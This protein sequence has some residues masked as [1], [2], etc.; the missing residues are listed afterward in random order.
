MAVDHIQS[1]RELIAELRKEMIGPDPSGNYLDCTQHLKF[2]NYGE[3]LGPWRQAGNGEEILTHDNPTI[4]YGMGVLY[5]RRS[6]IQE[7][8]EDSDGDEAVPD[9][10]AVNV[11]DRL[12][13]EELEALE[14]A[15][16]SLGRA[17][18]SEGGDEFHLSLA[19]EYQPSCLGISFLADVTDDAALVVD[20]TG[21]RY[22]SIDVKIEGY[23]QPLQFWLRSPVAMRVRYDARGLLTADRKRVEP[24]EIENRDNLDDLDIRIEVFSRPVGYKPLQRLITVSVVNYEEVKYGRDSHAIFQTEMMATM[25]D[26]QDKALI[27]PYPHTA[28]MKL[29]EEEQSLELLYRNFQTYAVG[30]GCAAD[31]TDIESNECVRQVSAESLPQYEIYS[32]SYDIQKDGRSFEVSMAP[33]AGLDPDDDGFAT[34][35]ELL[36]LYEAWIVEQEVKAESL[37]EVYQ[38][39]AWRHIALCRAALD[40]MKDGLDYLHSSEQ[41]LFA[42]RLA[43]HAI[44]LQQIQSVG[45][46]RQLSVSNQKRIRFSEP[47]EKP[48]ISNIPVRRGKWR[49]FQ[50]AFILMNLRSAVDADALD[51][52]TVDLIWFPTGGG[53]TEAYLGLS[54]YTMFMRRLQ[55]PAD[56][57]VSVLMR[58]TLR[59][60][61]AQQF[62]RASRLICAM[63][64]LRWENTEWL[65]EKE[66]S[67]G[68][69]VGGSNTP[70]QRKYAL[71]DLKKLKA[72]PHRA[73]NKFVLDHCPWCRAQMGPV[74]TGKTI[75]DVYG[76]KQKDNTVG[77]YCSDNQCDFFHGLPVYVIDEDIYDIRPSMVIGTVDKFA[78]LTWNPRV[79]A[80]FGLNAAGDRI[81]SPPGLIIQ[82]ELHLISGPLGSMVGIY[83]ALIEDLCTDYRDGKTCRPR[84]ISSTATIRSYEDQIRGLYAREQAALFPP[85]GLDAGDNFFST[86]ALD[87]EGRKLPGRLY[88]G[89]HAPGLGSSQTAQVRTFASLLQSPM[90]LPVEYQDPWW[91][92]LVFFNSLRELGAALTLFRSD[93]PEYLSALLERK[94]IKMNRR[95]FHNILELTGRASS[96]D[97]V[98]AISSL[99]A[100]RTGEKG[101]YP[102]DVCLASNILEV[103]VDIERLSLMAV[104]GQP[105]TTSQYIQVTGRVGRRADE[106]PG[107][108]LTIYAATKPRDR[109]HFEKFRT[110]H[111]RLYAQV[112]PTSVTAFSP[113]VI[114]RALHAIMVA[115]VRQYGA[116][117][118]AASNPTPVPEELLADLKELILKRVAIIDPEETGYVE[119][120]FEKRIQEWR[121]ISPQIYNPDRETN[122]PS[123]I[124]HAGSYIEPEVESITW[125]APTSLRSVDAE[126]LAEIT[127]QYKK[128]E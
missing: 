101:P 92:L 105:K 50:I 20:F 128:G 102:V 106:R 38:D 118:G 55:D 121:N 24:A 1:R 67:I 12:T 18:E 62:Q 17:S 30:H 77:L 93:I 87:E 108:I 53:K 49:A 91:T 58:Y 26:S 99:Q 37:D 33:L 73:Q 29:D 81:A 5:P 71:Q 36:R 104:V 107:L 60:L 66:F 32:Y 76:Y 4:R 125:P 72:D 114:D 10:S 22:R 14:Q 111:E 86:Y 46:V 126:C 103:G 34:L 48:D 2:A 112:E 16:S 97:I 79:R 82:D 6:R 45:N 109:S 90:N 85:S 122:N 31:W 115:Y 19:N 98:G 69:W 123:L 44:L 35:Q 25:V 70:N 15:S 80:L 83:E 59:L 95:W 21:G 124:Y 40:R 74:A 42:F 41:A 65:G 120:I 63:E 54:A 88:V 117:G 61:T 116:I 113:P 3:A 51:R 110:Y 57:G 94:G 84:I 8:P 11:F 78:Q 127:L 7:G 75:S 100:P 68:I 119:R 64:Y 56:T 39:A 23:E 27:R 47:L 43:N 28:T 9:I 13:D 96:A 52:E 89:I